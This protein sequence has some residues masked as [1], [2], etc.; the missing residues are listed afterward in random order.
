AVGPVLVKDGQVIR[1]DFFAEDAEG[2]WR[3]DEEFKAISAPPGERARGG[4]L[5]IPPTRFPHTVNQT[6]APRTAIGVTEGG[7]TLLFVVD[8]RADLS[9]SVGVTLGE[10]A[11]LLKVFG[12][13]S[14]LNLDGGGSSVMFVAGAKG[15]RH[16]LRGELATGIVNLPSDKGGVERLLPVP[17]V[18]VEKSQS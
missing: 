11:R 8:G 9:H 7:E 1:Q 3:M 17:L 16:R 4:A 2:F 15:S 6:R 12:V 5:G 18:F 10:L 14:A 13:S